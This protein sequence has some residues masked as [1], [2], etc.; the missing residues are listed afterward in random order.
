MELDHVRGEKRFHFCHAASFKLRD[1]EDRL[2]A[3]LSEIAKCDLRCPNC[4]KM[5]HF[6]ESNGHFASRAKEYTY[7]PIALSQATVE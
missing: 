5:R 7:A 3:V 6:T 1:G 2:Q 4:H